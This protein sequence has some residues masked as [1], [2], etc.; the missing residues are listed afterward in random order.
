[1]IDKVKVMDQSLLHTKKQIEKVKAEKGGL[2]RKSKQ[3]EKDLNEMESNIKL[4][5]KNQQAVTTYLIDHKNDAALV[6]QY[7]EI[8]S[9]FTNYIHLLEQE[10][11]LEKQAQKE[12]R[13]LKKLGAKQAQLISGKEGKQAISKEQILLEKK[14]NEN[15]EEIEDCLSNRLFREIKTALKTSQKEYELT[16]KIVNYE[17][18][19]KQLQDDEQCPLCGSKTHPFAQGNV[20][21]IDQLTLRIASLQNQIEQ[22]N[23]LLLQ[24]KNIEKDQ[25]KNKLQQEY[26][27]LSLDDV[28]AQIETIE[29]EKKATEK[30]VLL[31][32]KERESNQQ[33]LLT[34]LAYYGISEFND[35]QSIMNALKLRRSK[36]QNNEAQSA[37]FELLNVELISERSACEEKIVEQ[38]NQIKE[39]QTT[40]SELQSH[41]DEQSVERYSLFQHKVVIEEEAKAQKSLSK[42]LKEKN[43][44]NINYQKKIENSN[45]NKTIIE[46][47]EKEKVALISSV[48][49]AKNNWNKALGHSK[50]TDEASYLN[51]CVSFD[52][53]SKWLRLQKE[54]DNK[55]AE[56]NTQIKSLQDLLR[57]EE[58]KEKHNYV[59]VE[60]PDKINKVELLQ[61]ELQKENGIEQE[62]IANNNKLK[63]QFSTLEEEINAQKTV[64]IPWEKLNELIGQKDGA[65]F[66]KF[67]Q[68]LT[69]EIMVHHANDQLIK[70]SDRYLLQRDLKEPLTLKIIDKYQAG[71]VRSTDNLSGGESFI[72][73]LSLALGL[74]KM[75]SDKVSVG[76]L[77][78]DEGFGT[79]DENA[80]DTALNTLSSL[81][82]EG[83]LIGII[84]HVKMLKERITTQI[85]VIPNNDGSSS[86]SGPG[87]MMKIES[88]PRE[89]KV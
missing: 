5:A 77:F 10:K 11:T 46:T 13:L 44:S 14:W 41:Y 3:L 78:L 45:K 42:A 43:D 4:S 71:E 74:S 20:P 23:D 32:A 66:Q 79:L 6:N 65:K 62:K 26:N 31:L 67:A 21:E 80:L 73:S 84:S 70:M 29:Q 89:A 75:A 30:K 60:L 52:E 17:A 12:A 72:V 54:L 7:A 36:W 61:G 33:K 40:I 53:R 49:L 38:T 51:A 2:E 34:Q 28:D 50:L 68:G 85:E 25:E 81:H 39:K 24:Q 35:P 83:K 15:K 64:L 57:K 47:L 16:L 56:I 1:V 55:Q 19:R 87:V 27:T 59:A 58:C 48:D 76:S 18:D 63:Q 86:L 82:K 9:G 37:R 8:E 69:F 22:I 88:A